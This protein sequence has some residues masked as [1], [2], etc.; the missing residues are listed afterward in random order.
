MYTLCSD[1]VAPTSSNNRTAKWM[2]QCLP[3]S[4][5]LRTPEISLMCHLGYNN[6]EL[7]ASSCADPPASPGSQH[8]LASESPDSPHPSLSVF[9]IILP[10][11]SPKYNP[12]LLRT[13]AAL[14]EWYNPKLYT[15]SQLAHPP[16]YR[17]AI[18]GNNTL[19]QPLA[20]MPELHYH[21]PTSTRFS[22]W[23]CSA[24]CLETQVSLSLLEETNT[25]EQM[26]EAIES[27]LAVDHPLEGAYSL[28]FLLFGSKSPNS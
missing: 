24:E 14:I 17:C 9:A 8:A 6:W 4:S 19:L 16:Q 13:L 2:Q 20:A 15:P 18:T 26:R 12:L 21:L 1:P 23:A 22:L 5:E 28:E 27:I 11:L 7:L 25:W 3:T 10:F